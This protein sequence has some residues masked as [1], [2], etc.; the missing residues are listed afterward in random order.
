M[1]NEGWKN[2]SEKERRLKVCV[3]FLELEWFCFIELI[4][5][6]VDLENNFIC[7]DIKVLEVI[8]NILKY[9]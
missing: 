5:D 9:N 6:K 1:G 2:G 3:Y 7:L 8:R 4:L